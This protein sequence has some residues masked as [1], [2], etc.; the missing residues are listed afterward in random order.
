MTED[1][2]G[3]AAVIPE[4]DLTDMRVIRDPFTSYGE[5]RESSPIA[6]L[7]IPGIGPVWL[8]TRHEG[9]RALLGDPRFGIRSESFLRPGVPEDCLPYMRT[10][11]EMEGPEH[12]R[13]RKLVAPA[14]SVRRAAEFR[15]RIE[16]LVARLLDELPGHAEGGV[17]DLMRHYAR[18]LPIDVICELVGIPHADRPAWREYGAVIASGSGQGLAEALPGIIGG[19]KE[20][21]ARR[22][23]DPGDDLLSDL[24]R[25]HDD[26]DRLSDTEMVTMV[27]LLVLAGQTPHNLIGNAVAALLA[28]PEQLAALRADPGLMPRAVEELMRWCG[29]VLLA[30]P[31]YA[32][33]D[34]ELY[35]AEIREGDAITAAVAAA[36]RDPRAFPD[37][38]RLDVTRPAAAPHLGFSHG[39]HFCLG[40]ALAR[41]QTETALT[42]LL[43]RHPRLA[44]A[45]APEETRALD[46]G[47]WRLTSLPVTL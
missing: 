19:A 25:A 42:A 14:F 32:R 22:R 5:I 7:T 24:I 13:L 1:R 45:T 31:R 6:R 11:S 47:T 10:M 21:L 38:D 12:V 30:I 27:W 9:A 39:P 28:H 41:V 8:L 29:P 15:P 40:A 34:A 4:I 17:V 26:D 46:P 36:N 16:P 2:T 37:P 43:E 35:G 20:A 44:L 23:A 3:A 18:P 33:E